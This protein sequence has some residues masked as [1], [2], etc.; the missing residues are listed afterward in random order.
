MN[1]LGGRPYLSHLLF[2]RMAKE[3]QA[4]KW[5]KFFNGVTGGEIFLDP[6]RRYLRHLQQDSELAG[7]FKNV[8]KEN[9][10]TAAKLQALATAHKA[11]FFTRKRPKKK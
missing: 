7:A 6:L 8:I 3:P 2:F 9:P 10:E 1:Y 4:Q 11:K 5:E